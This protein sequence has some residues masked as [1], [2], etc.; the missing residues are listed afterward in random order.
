MTLFLSLCASLALAGPP[1]LPVVYRVA[2][3]NAVHHEAEID[4]TFPAAKPGTLYVR[5]SRSSPGRYALHEFAKNVY[6][7]RA[8]DAR[9]RTLEVT[10]TDPYGWNVVERGGAVHVHY[11]LFGDRAGGT[12]TGIDST[13]ARLN[14][15]ATFM[16]AKPFAHSPIEITFTPPATSKWKPATQ[17]IPTAKPWT[18]TAPDLQYFMDSPTELSDYTLR[19]WTVSSEGRT[20]TMRLAVHHTGTE[21]QVDRYAEMAK[22][23]VAEEEAVFGEFPRY[24]AGTYTFI[25]DYVPWGAG[26][27]MEHRNSTF[28]SSTSSLADN[29]LGLLGTLAHEYFHSWNMER[30]RAK[31]I[32]PFDFTRANPSP[33]L[34]FGE[35]FTNYYGKLALRR[36]GFY[37]DSQ[38][39]ATTAGALNYV[40][41]SP[42][43]RLRSPA[44]MSLLSPFVDA[45][46]SIDPT[47]FANTYISYYPWGEIIALGLD[48]TIRE[49]YPGKTLDGFMR[50]MWREFGK[51]TRPYVVPH[52][53]TMHDLERTLG[54]YVGDPAFAHE[55][56]RRYIRGR[57]LMDYATLLAPAGFIVRPAHPG[58]ALLGLARLRFDGDGGAI[59]SQ[60]LVG[61]PLYEAG[62]DRGDTIRSIGGRPVTNERDWQ[63]ILAAHQPGDTATVV[64]E[65]RGMV[66]RATVTFAADPRIAIVPFEVAGRALSDSARA[67]REAWLG[68]HVQ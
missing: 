60:T 42:G 20:Y 57:E 29:M 12:Y 67:F 46:T 17:L 51:T 38:Y 6:G 3:P 45:A 36:A 24:D 25:A 21:A 63:A 58:A 5:M 31:E 59:A 41:T 54:A 39:G 23:V 65:Q 56:F 16:W 1:A 35:G 13:H 33:E 9:G 26:D 48:L 19:T 47:N 32:E 22:R 61:M 40:L 66:K 44:D 14:M 11:T 37:D 68:S 27:G 50:T 30:I 8:T 43:R 52:P 55:V 7:V 64:F 10:R 4:V 15:P 34:W 28:I 2:F 62:L 18:F 49:R 53:Y